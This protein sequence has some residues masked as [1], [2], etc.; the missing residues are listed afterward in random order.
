MFFFGMPGIYFLN[1]YMTV[2][3]K[4]FRQPHPPPF[5]QG[6]VSCFTQTG[7]YSSKLQQLF[8]DGECL[9]LVASMAVG[10]IMIQFGASYTRLQRQD[11]II[12]GGCLP[13]LLV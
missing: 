4:I 7:N 1:W 6:A 2:D 12:L 13:Y 3:N 9:M 11:S 8:T 5:G 10:M